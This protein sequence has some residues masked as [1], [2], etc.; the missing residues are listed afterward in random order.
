MKINI[1]TE[2]ELRGSALTPGGGRWEARASRASPEGGRRLVRGLELR[3]R[4]PAERRR[5]AGRVD[6][7]E[8]G[9]EA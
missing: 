6:D 3:L 1:K 4:Q 9:R 8:K 5:F 2:E 7:L